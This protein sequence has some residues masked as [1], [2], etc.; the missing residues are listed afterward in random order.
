MR[1]LDTVGHEVLATL[2]VAETTLRAR[3]TPAAA[4]ELELASGTRAVAII[5]TAAIHYLG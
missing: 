2:R 1:A 4:R 3:I 5:K